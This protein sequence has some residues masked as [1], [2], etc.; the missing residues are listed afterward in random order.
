MDA[1]GIK[2]DKRK[3]RLDEA[4]KAVGTHM[5]EVEI[6]GGHKASVKTMVVAE[7]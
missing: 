2:V 1:R 5:V 7:S 4:I 3:I 6:A